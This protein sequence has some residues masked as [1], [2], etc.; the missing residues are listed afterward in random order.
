MDKTKCGGEISVCVIYK[1][2][3]HYTGISVNSYG[4]LTMNQALL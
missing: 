1:A 3:T 2:H 4:M